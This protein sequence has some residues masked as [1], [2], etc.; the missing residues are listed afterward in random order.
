R[1]GGQVDNIEGLEAVL[2][3]DGA[4]LIK[5]GPKLVG[6]MAPGDRQKVGRWINQIHANDTG[7]LSPYMQQA[8]GFAQG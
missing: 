8:V 3:P 1:Y 7:R 4:Y 5:F 2:M 6:A